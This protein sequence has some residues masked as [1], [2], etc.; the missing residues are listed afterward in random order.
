MERHK[1]SAFSN[2]FGSVGR[3]L[4]SIA[5][6]IAGFAGQM[7]PMAGMAL[8]GAL[9]GPAGAMMG[10]GLGGMAGG[11]LG[12]LSGGGGGGGSQMPQMPSYGQM[13]DAGGQLGGQLGN[14]MQGQLP[15]NMQGMNFG[16]MAGNA[17]G[18]AGNYL[19]RQMPQN[20]QGMNLGGMASNFM[21]NQFNQRVPENYRNMNF[22]HAGAE[23]GGR[24]AG[25]LSSRLGQMMPQPGQMQAYADGGSV[26]YDQSGYEQPQMLGYYPQ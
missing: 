1:M 9:G 22:G 2:F 6:P 24:F 3:G 19:N 17:F 11:A 8:G 20:M 16:Q 7:M 18:Q 26:G 10:Q 4:G 12:R 15:Q 13:S 21:Q 25:G 5:K 14:F 23:A